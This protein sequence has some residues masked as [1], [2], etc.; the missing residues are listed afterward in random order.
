MEELEYR[1]T[2][3]KNSYWISKSELDTYLEERRKPDAD[4]IELRNGSMYF[5][6]KFEGV[7]HRSALKNSELA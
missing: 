3:G 1:I 6:V 2:F 5:P 7:V 4:L